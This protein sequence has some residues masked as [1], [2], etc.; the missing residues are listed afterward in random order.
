[1]LHRSAIR[2]MVTKINTLDASTQRLDVHQTTTVFLTSTEELTYARGF[3][4]NKWSADIVVSPES[5]ALWLIN[6]IPIGQ[7]IDPVQPTRIHSIDRIATTIGTPTSRWVNYV[8]SSQMKSGRTLCCNL[9]RIAC[10]T[11]G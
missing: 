3:A 1:V 2:E 7:D 4:D 6:D 11:P 8:S 5:I 10:E 9:T